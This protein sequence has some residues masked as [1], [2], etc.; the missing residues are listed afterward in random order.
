MGDF[1][2]QWLTANR[3][4]VMMR[5]MKT[6]TEPREAGGGQRTRGK[7]RESSRSDC[8]IWD[9]TRIA[10]YL[11]VSASTLRRWIRAKNRIGR[12]IRRTEDGIY[13]AIP[14]ELEADRRRHGRIPE[15]EECASARLDRSAV[16][17]IKRLKGSVSA[18][19]VA[20]LASV[21]PK[22]IEN[23]WEGRTWATV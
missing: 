12:T 2:G 14:S 10:D 19:E 6:E 17:T 15:G 23:I 11:G 20:H 13:Y 4:I 21:S 22:T 7:R 8:P 16:K 1:L 3:V 5:A 18:Y 9:C